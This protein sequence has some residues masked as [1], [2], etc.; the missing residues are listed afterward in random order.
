MKITLTIPDDF[1]P[2]APDWA[3][4]MTVDPD[5]SVCFWNHRP[6][7]SGH[8]TEGG[9]DGESIK[10][11][12]QWDDMYFI[13]PRADWQACIWQR[14][15][16]NMSLQI[17]PILLEQKLLHEYEA[18]DHYE[19]VARDCALRDWLKRAADEIESLQAQLASY[20]NSANVH[21]SMLTGRIATISW[22]Q[23]CHIT[24]GVLNSEDAQLAEIVKLREELAEAK[25]E[26]ERLDKHNAGLADNAA[27]LLAAKIHA[28]QRAERAEAEL[29]EARALAR[30]YKEA[31]D[32]AMI[33]VHGLKQRAERAEATIERVRGLPERWRR[34]EHNFD[35][36]R[37]PEDQDMVMNPA[38][39]ADELEAALS[40]ER[41]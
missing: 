2:L 10:E 26:I 12:W 33:D 41:H 24:G 17:P 1:W 34:R 27:D 30:N 23:H 16:P 22:R 18:L 20:K 37:P 40:E 8:V 25:G 6:Q 11:G 29:A 31:W 7:E 21:A 13:P 5:G 39:C 15:K 14:P 36:S 35:C 4:W 32:G 28:E 3:E 38:D 19:M 9:W